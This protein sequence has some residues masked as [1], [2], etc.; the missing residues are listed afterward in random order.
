MRVDLLCFIVLYFPRGI[1]QGNNSF[2]FLFNQFLSVSES[3]LESIFRI[4]GN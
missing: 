4:R 1:I 3:L 2:L